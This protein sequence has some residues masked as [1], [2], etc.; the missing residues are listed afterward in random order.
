MRADLA[1]LATMLA[2]P[3]LAAATASSADTASESDVVVKKTVHQMIAET[4]KSSGS[5]TY[6][7]VPSSGDPQVQ[8]MAQRWARWLQQRAGSRSRSTR[9]VADIEQAP[10]RR[11]KRNLLQLLSEALLVRPQYVSEYLPEYVGGY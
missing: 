6:Q 2:L 3:L 1:A 5:E 9:D 10:K 11:D 8:F 7:R 4:L